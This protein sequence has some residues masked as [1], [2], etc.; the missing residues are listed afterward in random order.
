MMDSSKTVGIILFSAAS[1]FHGIGLYLLSHVKLSPTFGSNQRLY[2]INISIC[3]ILGCVLSIASTVV[4]EYAPVWSS[5]LNVLYIISICGMFIWY[6][7]LMTL[8]TADRFLS[9][10]LNIRY[11]TVC[12]SRRTKLVLLSLF[13]VSL[14]STVIC[15]IA[16]NHDRIERV[17]LLYVWPFLDAVFLSVALLTYIHFFRKIRSNQRKESLTT[18]SFKREKK[19]QLIS[20]K[21][22]KIKKKRFSIKR[23][24]SL[25]RG[26]FT[27]TLLVANFIVFWLIPDQIFFWLSILGK[28]KSEFALASAHILL[29]F[30]PFGILMDAII[31]IFFQR[32]IVSMLKKKLALG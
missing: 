10:Y 25:K 27:P 19:E 23:G 17:I 11:R 18:S 2:F 22:K 7:G 9:V 8:L 1:I 29:N 13:F 15:V 14:V 24:A 26:F 3:D 32:E 31:Y 30:Y 21:S 6:I 4:G 20:E 12:T 16:G 28:N 5:K